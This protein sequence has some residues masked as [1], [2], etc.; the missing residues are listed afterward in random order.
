MPA[1]V[2]CIA[3]FELQHS[4]S[5]VCR[6]CFGRCHGRHRCLGFCRCCG[7]P[8][9]S[10]GFQVLRIQRVAKF[11]LHSLEIRRRALR[12]RANNNGPYVLYNKR[13]VHKPCTER[14]KLTS[15]KVE[16]EKD[17]TYLK[18][19]FVIKI[20]CLKEI[21]F[22]Y[23]NV[24]LI[25]HY[26]ISPFSLSVRMYARVCVLSVLVRTSGILMNPLHIHTFFVPPALLNLINKT[27]PDRA[28]V[29]I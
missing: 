18:N 25:S 12:Q 28:N 29:A 15:K 26:L 7:D 22:L 11:P 5:E 13:S 8:P 10:P 27:I 14:K 19:V 24:L 17:A 2:Y 9:A 1:K 6:L 23:L 21:V 16:R 20:V 4:M 3:T